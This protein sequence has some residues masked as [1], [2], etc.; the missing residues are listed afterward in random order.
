MTRRASFGIYIPSLPAPT[1][2]VLHSYPPEGLF[3]V[4]RSIIFDEPAS[5][6]KSPQF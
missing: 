6:A 3:L 5:N 4:Y 1:V 2:D